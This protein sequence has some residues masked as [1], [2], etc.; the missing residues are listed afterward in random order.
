ML[1]S[2]CNI[3]ENSEIHPI[4]FDYH[5]GIH[6]RLE[7]PWKFFSALSV[8]EV[9]KGSSSITWTLLW[10]FESFCDPAKNKKKDKVIRKKYHELCSLCDFLA[11]DKKSPRVLT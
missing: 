7:N 10:D 11:N 3:F 9:G 2:P 1:H 8:K 4:H 6:P 5:F